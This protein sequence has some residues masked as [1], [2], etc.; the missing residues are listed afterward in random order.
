MRLFKYLLQLIK[1]FFAWVR[2]FVVD[3]PEEN[4][5]IKAYKAALNRFHG[6]PSRQTLRAA[7]RRNAFESISRA[8]P[9]LPRRTRR[10]MASKRAALEYQALMATV[11]SRV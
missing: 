2:W 8:L 7:L 11:D 6:F 5:R 1:D 9:K 4:K 10:L 3:R